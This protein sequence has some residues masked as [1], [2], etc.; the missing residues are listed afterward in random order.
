[1]SRNAL[2]VNVR[3]REKGKGPGRVLDDICETV[4]LAFIVLIPFC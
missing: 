4:D 2:T 1:V 3:E